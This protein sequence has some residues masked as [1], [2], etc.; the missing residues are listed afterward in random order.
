MVT[1]PAVSP[2]EQA[3]MRKYSVSLK[4]EKGD[5][6][7]TFFECSANDAEHAYDQAE[8]AHP[9]CETLCATEIDAFS[10]E[11][12]PAAGQGA[13][14]AY[15]S[16]L[17]ALYGKLIALYMNHPMKCEFWQKID[18]ANQREALMTIY[19]YGACFEFARALSDLT[20][21]PVY[22]IEWGNILQDGSGECNYDDTYGVHRVVKH[23]S[24]RYLDASGWTDLQNVLARFGAEHLPYHWMGETDPDG[25][26][27]EDIDSELVKQSV[28]TLL[29]EDAIA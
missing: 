1:A 15:E 2:T 25:G 11:E 10:D 8:T 22:D 19:T 26:V 7:T 16:R 12:T 27:F 23:P 20:H 14:V 21:W 28:L 5:K 13:S 18:L 24:G 3:K 6:F 29:P 4:A 17:Q 9:G